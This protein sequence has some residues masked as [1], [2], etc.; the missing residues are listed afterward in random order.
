[1]SYEQLPPIAR[2]ISADITNFSLTAALA[3][4]DDANDGGGLSPVQN[5]TLRARALL[6]LERWRAAYD[7]LQS[8]RERRDLNAAE[9]IEVQVLSAHVLRSA[10]A[11]V[12]FA[13]ELA[14]AAAQGAGR[15]G[16][17]ELGV[18][19]HLE[20]ARLFARKRCR[21]LG[22]K[23]VAAAAELAVLPALVAATRGDLLVTF[24][25]RPA[26]RDAYEAAAAAPA[27]AVATERA[28]A[29]RLS[30]LGLARL[31]V[32]LGEF[33]T[34]A[35]TLA[36]LPKPAAQDIAPR[37]AS[38]RLHAARADW[39]AVAGV[40]AEIIDISP[41]GDNAR[42]LQLE[43][44]SALYRAGDFDAARS[45]W[46]QIAAA[47]NDWASKIATRALG[48]LD[49]PAHR[50]AR[51][52]AF[53]SVT[54]L[55]NH[56][57]PA[58]VELCMRFFGTTAEQ[59]EIAREIKQPDGGT[60]VHRMRQYMTAAGFHTRRIEADLD[61]LRAILD[62][63]IP[64]IVEEDYSTSRHVAVAIGY[65]DRRE[66]L[67]VQDPMT[68]EVRET[69]YD[70]LPKLR[71]FSNH[72]ALVAVPGDRADLIAA[73]DEAG[74]VECDY[75]TTTDL[76]WEAHDQKRGDDADRLVAEAIAQHEAY[77]L[78]WVLRF[79]R[80]DARRYDQPGRD[81]EAALA[82]VLDAILRLWP[83]DEWP[84][85]YLG[86][87]RDSQ[88]RLEEALAAFE[89]ARDRDPDD[90]SN[91]CWIADCRIRM[92]DR[93]AARKALEE[94]LRRDPS[95][96]RSNENLADVA[97]GFGD[98]SLAKILND[99][100][101]ELSP[102]NAFN[103]YVRGRILGATDDLGDSI[104]AY[105]RALELRPDA[106]GFA[107]GR[108]R[109]M[110]RAGRV[111]D[112]ITSLETLRAKR[113]E[114]AHLMTDLADLAYNHERYEVC[115]AVCDQLAALD[116]ATATPL[117]IGGAARCMKGELDAGL[118]QLRAALTRRPTYAWAHRE[119]ARALAGASRWDE[120]ISASAANL[121]LNN[122][123]DAVYRFGDTLV[124]AGHTHDG[125]GYLRRAAR[126]GELTETQL[127]RVATTVF[128]HNGGGAAHDL[129]GSL[130]K[131][132]P[133]DLGIARAHVALLLEKLWAP[134]AATAPLSHLSELERD[135]PWV[136]ADQADALMHRSIDDEPRGEA[137][138]E[139]AIAA[140]PGL[141][142][143]R[144]WYARCLNTRGRFA[145]ALDVLTPLPDTAETLA[146]R[147]H[148]L[149][150][151]GREP[152]ATAAIER[153]FASLPVG[154]PE[155]RRQPLLYQIAYANRRWDECLTLASALAAGAGEL[156]DDGKLGRWEAARFECL[157]EL[158]R[159]DEALAFGTAQ[160]GTAAEF[161]RLAYTAL[162]SRGVAV[163][164][165]LAERGHALAPNE[166]NC[167]TT[168]ARLADIDGD[169]DR[170][171]ELWRGLKQL[172]TWHIH[173]EN[174][175]RLAMSRGDFVA[176]QVHVDPAVACGH[177]C[178]VAWR[179]R[180]EL[181]LLQGDRPRALA[182]AERAWACLQLELRPCSPALEGLLAGLRGEVDV[183]EEKLRAA[184]DRAE[185]A[186]DRALIERVAAALAA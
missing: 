34:A 25:E 87:V 99:C 147:V 167:L 111:D 49:G 12:D 56:C 78:A 105:D 144:R 113:P 154:T 45:A 88:D 179:H 182:A 138:F 101:L 145:A 169:L 116:P 157:I 150:G 36:S 140:G 118:A 124:A 61:H 161:G 106:P 173:D 174:L 58:S 73:L 128:E 32:I 168:L 90:P 85:Q 54:Q 23:A 104:A 163:A 184:L 181:A 14:L 97:F 103:W 9:R 33:D 40:L 134:G 3:R 66:I 94:A 50:R 129:F 4:L 155:A 146:D 79:V 38:W 5:G 100:A 92:N 172:S 125:V 107:V 178:P 10:S 80:A 152:E 2:S 15:A 123:P 117:A 137:L 112:A 153:W 75:I 81:S 136:L 57:G 42:S 1:M 6:G 164:R 131:E 13:L 180:A 126:S 68:H 35:S 109:V 82:E 96:T 60:P 176:A 89:R 139:R 65:D 7:L 122:G 83:N 114:D 44:A 64:V 30:R 98:Q 120:A 47:T 95:H 37:R 141:V 22:D 162:A 132:H 84:Q 17:P 166:A 29:E 77:E 74:A 115:L 186:S 51:L 41:D 72:G 142:A 43:R 69:S 71:E 183:S 165:Q 108:A 28:H 26:A 130:A 110:A 135:S 21:A 175:G 24:D 48:K 39:P 18:R 55:R 119:M 127:D 31:Q 170:A 151:L 62:R 91:W 52:H 185:S 8:I 148:A 63:G 160:C 27:D 93:Q 158:G 121:G 53:P 76:A 11:S 133:R 70:E 159:H 16:A 67:E 171:D 156:D 149:L 19:A 20:A 143:P 177:T 59:I 102:S 86:R 46:T